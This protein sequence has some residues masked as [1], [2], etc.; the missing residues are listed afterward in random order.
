MCAVLITPN[1][2]LNEIEMTQEIKR[3]FCKMFKDGYLCGNVINSTS[4]NV[5]IRDVTRRFLRIRLKHVAVALA[6]ATILVV[7]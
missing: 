6:A 1:Q 2:A 7:L 4:V 3:T 5:R